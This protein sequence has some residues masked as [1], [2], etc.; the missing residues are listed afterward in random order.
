MSRGAR[1]A[2]RACTMALLAL[3][4]ACGEPEPD[5]GPAVRFSDI[6]TEIFEKKCTFAC[7]SGGGFGA[8]GLDLQT[9]PLGALVDAAPT[10]PECS[11][12]ATPRVTPGDPEASLL[13][14][15]IVARI[16]GTDPPCGAP[17]PPSQDQ[18]AVTE[19]EAER[20]RVWIEQGATDD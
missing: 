3:A 11:G 20:I 2:R 13:Y 6:N 10:S 17:M 9:D 1:A 19:E 7:H 15:K 5:D 12:N 18:P 16:D 4:T 14:L 8:G